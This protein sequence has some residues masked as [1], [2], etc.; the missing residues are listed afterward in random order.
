MQELEISPP[1]EP[2]AF[3]T[4]R[5]KSSS[6][7]QSVSQR[8]FVLVFAAVVL[9]LLL[10]GAIRWMLDHPFAVH[11]DEAEY[12]NAVQIDVQR[13]SNGMLLK[14]AGRILLKS[15][16]RPP[17]YRILADPLLALFGF[18]IFTARMISLACFTLS[19][20]FIYLAVRRVASAT[21]AAI[22]ALI[23][24][25]SPEVVSASIFFGTDTAL[26]LATSATFYY[27]LCVWSEPAPRSRNWIGL[28]VALGLGFLAKTSFIIIALPLLAFWAVASP[29]KKLRLPSPFSQ[30]KAALLAG[31]VAG[32]WWILNAKA[33]VAYGQ[34]ARG[35]V[36]NSL[37]AP[38][39]ATGI[40]WLNT[41]VQCL[42]GHGTSVLICLLL[43]ALLVRLANR[44]NN[45]P[46]SLRNVALGACVC[47]GLPIVIAQVSGTN[48]LL[49]HIS[50]AM[51]PL[52]IAVGLLFE[53]TGW[54][55]SWRSIGV[56]C[57]LLCVQLGMLLTPV[58]SPNRREVD[59]GFVN[60]ALPWRTMVR[61]DQWEW[62]AVRD[63][64]DNCGLDDPTISY[65]GNGRAFNKPQ[66]AY[67][68]VVRGTYLDVPDPEW[69]WRYE[70]G[71]IVWQDTINSA[72]QSDIVLTAPNFAGEAKYKE[73]QDN[74]YNAEFAMRLSHDQHFRPPV[75]ILMGR[76]E[77]VEVLVFV[78]KDANCKAD[79][80]NS[81]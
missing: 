14:F 67:P 21:A 11:W 46:N 6:R 75:R 56:S 35:F 13:L 77:P 58:I 8:R 44:N 23:F 79:F 25:L 2:V 9:T 27:L 7:R 12:F 36:R 43:I 80:G 41:V 68:W 61:F 34:Y 73:D 17:A 15:W 70:N 24:A 54:T 55:H 37:G 52:A 20:G 51:I 30:W 64:T 4:F 69:L 33:A 28:G 5:A 31:V 26:Y 49:R 42:L 10:A 22:A 29:W 72:D 62:R 19:C 47:A 48:H 63:I 60:G 66:I 39:L 3:R 76:F 1:A 40:R 50:P 65:L 16:G 45:R 18:H 81:Q 78:N 53:K 57:G 38:S 59:L 71:P 74:R 32:P